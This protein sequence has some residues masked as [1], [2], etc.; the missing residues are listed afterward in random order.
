MIDFKISVELTYT[1]SSFEEASTVVANLTTDWAAASEAGVTIGI[2]H[3]LHR[4]IDFTNLKF[5][6]LVIFR[7]TSPTELKARTLEETLFTATDGVALPGGASLTV[8]KVTISRV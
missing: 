4:V 2:E 7:V 8:E 3:V 5:G 1:V 6:F